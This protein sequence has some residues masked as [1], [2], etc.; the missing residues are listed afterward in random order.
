MVWREMVGGSVDLRYM[1]GT[2]ISENSSP[3]FLIQLTIKEKW[4]S[5]MSE[6]RD[7]F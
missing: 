7:F 1:F 2:V 4:Y 3:F 6:C 5:V